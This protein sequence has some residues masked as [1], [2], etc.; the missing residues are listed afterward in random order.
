VKKDNFNLQLENHFLKERLGQMA[1]D[2]I[3]AALKENVKLKLEIL[4]L[5]KETKKI[6]KLLLQQDR[7]LSDVQRER[8]GAHGTKGELK[9]LERLYQGERERR[10]AAE[11]ELAGRGTGEGEET[12]RSR[13]EQLEIEV[14][15][16]KG[17]L[18]D[19]EQ[20]LAAEQERADRAEEAGGDRQRDRGEGAEE[21]ED[22]SR[23]WSEQGSCAR[24]TR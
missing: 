24:L 21:L 1:P 3:E 12:W 13:C 18:E 9:E 14:E 22:V 11:R 2:H 20:D 23:P 17:G 16:L 10:R 15:R 7:D 4:N 19:L 5:S 8:E 6:K